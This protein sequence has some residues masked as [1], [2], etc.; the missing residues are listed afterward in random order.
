M[1][2]NPDDDVT[3]LPWPLTGGQIGECQAALRVRLEG[4][5]RRLI[6][7]LRLGVLTW[8]RAVQG[9]GE[10]AGYEA[11]LRD[12]E[13]AVRERERLVAKVVR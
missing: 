1:S 5:M 4:I 6:G 2:S 13:R 3:L 9:I 11:V 12:F 7:D 10:L 8:D